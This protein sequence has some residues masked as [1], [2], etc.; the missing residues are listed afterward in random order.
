MDLT[1]NWGMGLGGLGDLNF[2]LVGTWLE[3]FAQQTDADSP[4]FDFAS[5]IGVLTGQS[6][7]E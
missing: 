7:P 2:M 1:L 6:L 5:S 3:N 4:S